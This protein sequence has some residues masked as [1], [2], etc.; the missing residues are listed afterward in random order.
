[1]QH[2]CKTISFPE[3]EWEDIK[4][5]INSGKTCSTVRCCDELGKYKLSQTYITP[6]NDL[7]K[8][9]KIENYNKAE[10]IPTWKYWG[11]TMRKSVKEGKVHGNNEWE[12]IEFIKC[13]P[14]LT[15]SS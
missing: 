1:M 7:I 5:R 9:T 15:L 11:E 2:K 10:D 4:T 13:V 14:K 8:I 3:E 12:Y 6:W